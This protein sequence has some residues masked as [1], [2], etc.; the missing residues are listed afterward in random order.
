MK[1]ALILTVLLLP[2]PALAQMGGMGGA[3]PGGLGAA[4]RPRGEAPRERPQGL[5]GLQSRTAPAIP[6]A[7]VTRALNP[8]EMLFDAISRGDVTAAREAV[9]RGAD[10][11]SRNVLGLTALDSAV[12]QGRP[13]MIFYL[14]SLRGS[15]G[16]AAP[17]PG[18][19]PLPRGRAPR[20][21]PA[22]RVVATAPSAPAPPARPR[23]WA[24]DGGAA[25]PDVG[26]LGFDAGRPAGAAP[27]TAE[28]TE[29]RRP[30]A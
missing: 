10:T 14:L 19:A 30:R 29:R 23:L 8:N 21:E 11:N 25:Q 16:N 17:P 9:N 3:G 27:R 28:P 22:P 20:P 1:R 18:G 4:E 2:V 13:E 5:P 26:F 7:D 12:D 15:A 24:N 6:L